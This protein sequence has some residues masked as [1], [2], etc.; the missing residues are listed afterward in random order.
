MD[1]PEPLWRPLMNHLH[2]IIRAIRAVG[3][4]DLRRGREPLILI[5]GE[6]FGDVCRLRVREETLREGLGVDDCL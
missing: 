1:N 4:H 6:S 5:R 3:H 2:H